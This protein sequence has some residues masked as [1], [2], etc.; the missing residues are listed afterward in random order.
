[1]IPFTS[2]FLL[3]ETLLCRV[4]VLKNKD[5]YD[6]Q[7]LVGSA[8]VVTRITR[9]TRATVASVVTVVWCVVWFD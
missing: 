7:Y 9:V 4:R 1:M 8:V 5:K 6:S 2:P 3:P